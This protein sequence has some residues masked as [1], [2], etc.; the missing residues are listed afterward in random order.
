M[1]RHLYTFLFLLLFL[2]FLAK[3][4]SELR[5]SLRKGNKAMEVKD[6]S[7][8]ERAYRSAFAMDSTDSAVRYGLGNALYEQK[9]YD[10]AL[11]IYKG[12]DPKELTSPEKVANLMHNMGNTLLQKKQFAPASECFKQSLRLNPTDDETRYNLALALKQIKEQKKQQQQNQQQKN[13]DQK[14]QD[15]KKQEQNKKQQNKNQQNK[16]KQNKQEIDKKVAQQI[17][18]AYEQDDQKTRQ[19]YEKGKQELQPSQPR[20]KKRW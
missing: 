14:K 15:K 12:I 10:E 8:A 18:K 19:R 7:S 5:L 17:L 6:Y 4:Q 11:K 20:N 2:P 3:G 9:K 16:K 13:Q 1:Q